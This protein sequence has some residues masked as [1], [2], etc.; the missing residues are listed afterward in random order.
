MV[1][2][3]SGQ[4]GQTVVSSVEEEN[5]AVQEPAPIPLRKTVEKIATSWDQLRTFKTVTQTP[6]VSSSFVFFKTDVLKTLLFVMSYKQIVLACIKL[7]VNRYRHQKESLSHI[8]VHSFIRHS[9][10]VRSFVRSFEVSDTSRRK[11]IYLFN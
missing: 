4:S 11:N 3:P 8:F 9:S 5:R 6:A 2:T 7:V 10:F 1:T